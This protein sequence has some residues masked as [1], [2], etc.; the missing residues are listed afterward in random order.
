MNSMNLKFGDVT[1]RRSPTFSDCYYAKRIIFSLD[2]Y[3]LS[4]FSIFIVL[5]NTVCNLLMSCHNFSLF[6][7]V[8][9]ILL[10]GDLLILKIH[11]YKPNSMNS[12]NSMKEL[13]K[14]SINDD[15]KMKKDLLHVNVL[16]CGKRNTFPAI[17]I[18]IYQ[19][20][21]KLI[22]PNE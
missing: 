4:I 7:Q 22:H 15:F 5:F 10:Y 13:W 21:M 18:K 14:N 12:L 8:P 16:Q 19:N 6:I 11:H 9:C 3:F 17:F 2:C 20:V 1:A